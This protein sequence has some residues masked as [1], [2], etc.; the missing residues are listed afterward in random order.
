MI[1]SPQPVMAIPN[2]MAKNNLNELEL[3]LLLHYL[4]QKWLNWERN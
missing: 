2:K 3:A 4:M 1:H